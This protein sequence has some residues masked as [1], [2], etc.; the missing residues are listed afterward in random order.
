MLPRALQRTLAAVADAV[1]P[2]GG[3]FPEGA[4]DVDAAG[5]LLRTWSEMQPAARRSLAA[6]LVALDAAALLRT[7]RRW[8]ALPLP[9][10]VQLCDAL[11]QRGGAVQRSAFLG[12][13][14]LVLVGFAADPRVQQR[15]GTEGWPPQLIRP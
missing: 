4:A 2:P 3:A 8:H 13:K 11:E 14:T 6:M 12:V 15:L 10:R 1:V 7:G 9:R 5:A